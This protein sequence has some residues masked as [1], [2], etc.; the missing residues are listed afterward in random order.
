MTIM[1]NTN[2][3]N[4]FG[5]MKLA[6]I[7]M[8]VSL[9]L[10][11]PRIVIM[12]INPIGSPLLI[13]AL[14]IWVITFILSGI[15]CLFMS[16]SMEKLVPLI[17]DPENNAADAQ[18]YFKWMAICSFL[19][20]LVITMLMYLILMIF[21]FTKLNKVFEKLDNQYAQVS[22]LESQFFQI[23]AWTGIIVLVADIFGFI[24]PIVFLIIAIIVF[25]LDITAAY[26]LFNYGK[27]YESISFVSE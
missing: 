9:A 21:A 19:G 23:Y 2:E 22:N 25:G 13:W 24:V 17:E 10:S 15:A 14:V 4:A 12:G 16:N 18:K 27:K 6:G 11:L 20:F 3:R 8:F 26:K 1:K 5:D 7:L